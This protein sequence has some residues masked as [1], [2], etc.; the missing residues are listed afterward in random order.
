MN[1]CT[2]EFAVVQLLH[3]RGK[4]GLGLVFDESPSIALPANLGVDN[5]QS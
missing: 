1:I 4:I 2:L 3:S 5:I